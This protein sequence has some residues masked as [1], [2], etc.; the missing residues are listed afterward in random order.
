LALIQAGSE[1][2]RN[3]RITR[4]DVIKGHI[5]DG[6]PDFEVKSEELEELRNMALTQVN[7]GELYAP[8]GYELPGQRVSLIDGHRRYLSRVYKAIH[9]DSESD[10]ANVS[11]ESRLGNTRMTCR[12]Y[13]SK[14][15]ASVI[16]DIAIIGNIQRKE[17]NV[18]ETLNWGFDRDQEER[19]KNG[20]GLN[21]KFFMDR[22]GLK[23]SQAHK[24][25]KIISVGR[26]D[27]VDAI[28]ALEHG[29]LTQL[30]QM[31]VIAAESNKRKRKQ[32][33]ERLC[34]KKGRGPRRTTSGSVMLGKT[35]N[36]GAVKAL[37]EAAA[38]GQILADLSG[39]N[40]EDPKSVSRAFRKFL[41]AWE[42]RHGS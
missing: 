12:V 18:L 40:W 1:Q 26:Q 7:V 34:S 25:A 28:A 13:P 42:I 33:I 38:D 27:L 20:V 3:I 6:D 24:W 22:I 23:S 41:K 16:R 9:I 11:V 30:E 15:A 10:A 17:L 35:A 36:L 2:P 4:D 32:L 14:P 39:T 8:V 37:I 5:G 19:T 29:D 31:H 21:A